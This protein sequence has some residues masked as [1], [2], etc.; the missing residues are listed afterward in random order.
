MSG[1]FMGRTKKVGLAGRF[2]PR[3]GTKA[4]KLIVEIE[5]KL[6]TPQKCPSCGAKKV[7][8]LATA[9]WK[10]RHCGIKFAGA[11]YVPATLTTKQAEVSTAGENKAR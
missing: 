1:S 3:Y 9:I 2:G 8:R 10:C 7:R 11:A 4:R 5:S 6:R